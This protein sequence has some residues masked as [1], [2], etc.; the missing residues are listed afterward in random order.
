L[1]LNIGNKKGINLESLFPGGKFTNLEPIGWT[2]LFSITKTME[3]IL[4]EE[5][6]EKLKLNQTNQDAALIIRYNR[7]TSVLEEKHNED[8]ND[9]SH[10]KQAGKF[11]SNSA[12]SIGK[13]AAL[14]VLATKLAEVVLN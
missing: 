7:P 11:L 6:K 12:R 8:N 2:N 10:L 5:L 4:E 1:S 14:S 13:S 9:E 3:S